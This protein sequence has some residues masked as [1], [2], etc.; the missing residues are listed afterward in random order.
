MKKKFDVVL[1]DLKGETMKKD[2]KDLNLKDLAVDCLLAPE[3]ENGQMKRLSGQDHI[4]RYELA[5][6]IHSS[7]EEINIDAEEISLIKSVISMNYNTFV[8]GPAMEL[9]EGKS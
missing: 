5:K 3:V 6:K 2:G 1:K 9:L 7:K 4:K 8:A